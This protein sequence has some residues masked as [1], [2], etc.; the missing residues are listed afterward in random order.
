MRGRCPG[1]CYDARVSDV[2]ALVRSIRRAEFSR[3][4]NFDAH[5]QPV[6]IEAR[7]LHRFLRGVERDLAGAT[8]VSV[9]GPANDNG[10]WTIT[11]EFS[12]V[13]YSRRVRLSADEYALLVE[14]ER[15][16]RCLAQAAAVAEGC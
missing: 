2:Y 3:N 16:R 8:A 5:A 10:A 15:V 11:M 9:S 1:A 14:E 7:R 13:R 6:A 12:S 4:R